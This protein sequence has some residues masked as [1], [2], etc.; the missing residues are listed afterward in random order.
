M[1]IECPPHIMDAPT[2]PFMERYMIRIGTR[3][4]VVFDG[5]VPVGSY[6]VSHYGSRAGVR[7]DCRGQGI[8]SRMIAAWWLEHPTRMPPARKPRRTMGGHKAGLRALSLIYPDIEPSL[9]A[10]DGRS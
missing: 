8:G 4:A 5:D 2:R 3:G 1:P 9:G 10:P 7:P 6:F